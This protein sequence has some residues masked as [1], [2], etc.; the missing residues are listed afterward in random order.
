MVFYLYCRPYSLWSPVIYSTGICPPVVFDLLWKVSFFATTYCCCAAMMPDYG[1]KSLLLRV[2]RQIGKKKIARLRV[3]TA[4]TGDVQETSPLGWKRKRKK[5]LA[6]SAI[7]RVSRSRYNRDIPGY[8]VTKTSP[9]ITIYFKCKNASDTLCKTL[10]GQRYQPFVLLC[11][12]FPLTTWSPSP[13]QCS[14]NTR[15][16]CTFLLS[17]PNFHVFSG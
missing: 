6:V 15:I 11:F 3:I 14:A 16:S 1:R 8:T 5:L 4:K 13:G 9:A 12:V 10:Q 2:I 7:N 17:D